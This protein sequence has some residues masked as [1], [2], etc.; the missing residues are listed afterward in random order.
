MTQQVAAPR[1]T[2]RRVTRA[3]ACPYRAL[4]AFTA[5]HAEWFHGRSATVQESVAGLVAHEPG[6][7]LLGPSGA[8]RS[9]LLRAGVLPA[10]A[11]GQLRAAIGAAGAR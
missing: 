10:L 3:D 8:G 4:E 9:S 2:K 6:I 5:V 11:A 7:R 1:T